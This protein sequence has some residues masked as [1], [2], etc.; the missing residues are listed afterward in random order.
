MDWIRVYYENKFQDYLGQNNFESNATSI[1]EA[2]DKFNNE[3]K[4][5]MGIGKEKGDIIETEVQKSSPIS[6][7]ELGTY[8]GYSSIRIARNLKSGGKLYTV[9]VNEKTNLIASSLIEKSDLSVT[10]S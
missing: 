4:F 1:I 5:Y 10:L 6:C 7:V 3:E 9:D 8:C 2:I